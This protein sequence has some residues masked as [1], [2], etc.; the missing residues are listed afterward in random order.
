MGHLDEKKYTAALAGCAKCDAKAFEVNSYLDREV[1]VMLASPSS[2]GKWTHDQGKL[3]DG[4]YRIRCIAC[5]D[6]AYTSDDCPRCHRAG[7][8]PDALTVASR[9]A[10]PQR[11]PTCKGTE[12]TVSGFAP[13][14]VRTGDRPTAPT[15]IAP[16]GNPGFHV[17]KVACGGCDWVAVPGGCPLCAGPGP[18]RDRAS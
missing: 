5:S 17:A 9:L 7:G 18:L 3:V 11:C 12:L 10:V 8:L 14:R 15:V 16:F 4:T 2:D 6:D 13:A 1:I